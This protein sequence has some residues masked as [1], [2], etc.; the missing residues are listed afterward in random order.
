MIYVFALIIAVGFT[1]CNNELDVPA[2]PIGN[3]NEVD[4]EQ[5]N[6]DLREFALAVI[7]YF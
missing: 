2:P 6:T 4:V 1:A 3:E 7:S 5:Y